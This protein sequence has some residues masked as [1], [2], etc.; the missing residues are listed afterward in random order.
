MHNYK[1]LYIIL[2]TWL[3]Q[4]LALHFSC[5]WFLCASF[6]GDTGRNVCMRH[7]PALHTLLSLY[8]CTSSITT[9]CKW[10]TA[11]FI[12]ENFIISF[13]SRNDT[14]SQE[15]AD[16]RNKKVIPAF[17]LPESRKAYKDT[18][19]FTRKKGRW[20]AIAESK[21]AGSGL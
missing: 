21:M 20:R 11:G 14:G 2:I 9:S 16:A 5:N 7:S 13:Q 12:L 17:L 19:T 4:Y 10:Y 8:D 1:I 6:Y 18:T 15:T 3:N